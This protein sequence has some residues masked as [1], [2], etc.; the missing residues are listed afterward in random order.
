MTVMDKIMQHI[1]SLPE[2]LQTE[3]LD[4]FVEYLEVKAGRNEADWA[5][6]SLSSAMRGMDDEPPLYSAQDLKKSFK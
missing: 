2:S 3:V 5:T 4:F 6:F 1:Q